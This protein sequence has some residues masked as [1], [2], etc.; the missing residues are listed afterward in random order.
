DDA[1]AGE[2][3]ETSPDPQPQQSRKVRRGAGTCPYCKDSEG[4]EGAS[5]G[6]R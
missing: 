1:A 6:S 3:G 2:E 4:R 5:G